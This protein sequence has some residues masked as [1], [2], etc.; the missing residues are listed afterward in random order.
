MLTQMQRELPE[1]LRP[2]VSLTM[3]KITIHLGA[4]G[5]AVRLALCGINAGHDLAKQT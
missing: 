3:R 5:C 1:S 4:E 2:H